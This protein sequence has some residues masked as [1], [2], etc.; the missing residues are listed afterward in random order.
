MISDELKQTILAELNLDDWALQENT[1][2]NMVPGWDSLSHA[3]I[4]AAVED[5]F[6]VRF[7]I[8]EILNLQTVGDLQALVDS[9]T[10]R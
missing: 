6:S 1:T 5:H 3:S 10:R 4:I 9:K 2:A 8:A 7:Q